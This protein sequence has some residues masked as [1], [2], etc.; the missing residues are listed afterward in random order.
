MTPPKQ[1]YMKSLSP[2][3]A[4]FEAFHAQNPQVFNKLRKNALWM[5]GQGKKRTSIKRL[6]EYLRDDPSMITDGEKFKLNNNYHAFYARKL[7]DENPE[8]RGFFVTRQQ[9]HER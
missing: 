1:T 5:H 6:Y 4:A 7:M 9:A 3:A 2:G 8:L